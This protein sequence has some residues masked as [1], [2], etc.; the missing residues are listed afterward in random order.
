MTQQKNDCRFV[1]VNVN[2]R[3]R[4]SGLGLG[5]G[6]SRGFE[7]AVEIAKRNAI[8]SASWRE[9]ADDQAHARAS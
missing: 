7:S 9:G 2:G 3:G 6:H 1:N 8:A 4:A 5:L